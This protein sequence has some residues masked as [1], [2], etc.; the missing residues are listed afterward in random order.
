MIDLVVLINWELRQQAQFRTSLLG[1]TLFGTSK[2]VSRDIKGRITR[3]S[4]TVSVDY[5]LTEITN[6]I[7]DE[8]SLTFLL[9]AYATVAQINSENNEFDPLVLENY[10]VELSKVAGMQERNQ[11]VSVRW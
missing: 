1:L 8:V 7:E 2:S 3:C 9:Y 6:F 4:S 10:N 11:T 5:D